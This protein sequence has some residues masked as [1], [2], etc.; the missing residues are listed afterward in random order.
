MV[1]CVLG[2][3]Q[4]GEQGA[5]GLWRSTWGSGRGEERVG[6]VREANHTV[7]NSVYVQTLPTEQATSVVTV[8][9]S[10]DHDPFAH[11]CKAR[12]LTTVGWTS[13]SVSLSMSLPKVPIRHLE[14]A[15]F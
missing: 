3:M 8:F 9:F 11:A 6:V 5:W 1:K 10:R 12:P 2:E 14:F 7:I 4:V 15:F 13:L